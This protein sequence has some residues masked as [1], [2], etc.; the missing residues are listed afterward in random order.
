MLTKPISA[1]EIKE[2][3]F[4]IKPSSGPGADGMTGLFFQ[5]YWSII[6]EQVTIEV[7]KFFISGQMPREWNYTQLRLIPKTPS[8]VQMSDLRPISLCSVSYKIISKILVKRLQ[9]FLPVI[10]SPFQYAFVAER[11]I[12]DNILIAHE[13]GHAL[14]T[15]HVASKE[16]VAMKSD[17]SKACDRVE[18]SYLKALLLALGFHS[19]WVEWIMSCVTTVTFSVLL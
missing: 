13:V 5:K 18:W 11:M 9:P 12:S 6:G 8:P 2:A 15:H 16:F 17:M 3:V 19:R 1:E 4:S 7:Q 10:V 14:H